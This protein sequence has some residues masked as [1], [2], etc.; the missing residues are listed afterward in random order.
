MPTRATNYEALMNKIEE[1]GADG[2][3][4]GGLTDENGA[5]VIKDKVKVLG[6]NETVK[7]YMPDGFTAAARSTSPASRTRAAPS[8]RLPAPH[9]GVR[10]GR[11]E[12]I[13]EFST[14]SAISRSTR[15]A[16]TAPRRSDARGDREL[17][18]HARGRHRAALRHR[19]EGWVPRR[20]QLQRE[21]RPDARLGRSRRLHDLPRRGT[22]RGRDFLLARGSGG[23]GRSHRL[24]TTGG[25]RGGLP[26]LPE[27][28]RKRSTGAL[29]SRLGGFRSPAP[30][31]FEHAGSGKSTLRTGRGWPFLSQRRR[32]GTCAQGHRTKISTRY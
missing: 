32:N 3:F 14:R 27:L 25:S 1:T 11:Q 23:R 5:Q 16:S 10:A 15:T 8:S 21:R 30:A 17:R 4:L 19:G 12:F 13:E 7:L 31:S 2:V 6:D 28:L 9:R 20:L 29:A 22:A 24:A 18:L 26:V